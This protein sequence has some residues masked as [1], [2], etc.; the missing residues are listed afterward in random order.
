MRLSGAAQRTPLRQQRWLG[1]KLARRLWL[2]EIH[3][4]QG[5]EE[6]ASH[7]AQCGVQLHRLGAAAGSMKWQRSCPKSP[8]NGSEPLCKSVR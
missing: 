1:R 6:R 7:K 2:L 3:E 5:H 8:S 4:L